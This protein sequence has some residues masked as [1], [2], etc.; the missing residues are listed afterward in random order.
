MP[1]EGAPFLFDP[2]KVSIEDLECVPEKR[3]SLGRAE[4]GRGP[5][6]KNE[7]VDVARGVRAP[8]FDE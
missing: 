4:F 3:S 7:G 8:K 1:Y 5:L 6:A 2:S